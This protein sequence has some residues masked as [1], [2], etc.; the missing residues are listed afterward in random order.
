MLFNSIAFVIFFPMVGIMYFILPH[1]YRWMLLLL[2]SYV[3]Y[4]WWRIEYA[5][6]ILISTI[7]DF[8]AAQ[9]MASLA[10]IRARKLYLG[11]SLGLNLG[12][13]ATFKYF[14]FL[15]N[16]FNQLLEQ[17]NISSQLPNTEWALP[18]GISFYTFQT[19]AYSIEV[20]RGNQKPEKHFG[21]F[22]L[23]VSFFPQ[24]VAGPI[25]RA[26]NLLPQFTK[27]FKFEY[28]NVSSGIKRAAW[29]MFKKVV[30]ADRLAIFVDAYYQNPG[31]HST[32][33]SWII[34][35][36]F[37]IQIYCD[38]SGYADIAIGSARVMGF[39]LMENFNYP[40]FARNF[41]NFW[42]RWHI[43]LTTWFRD[44]IYFPLG[45]SLN[46]KAQTYINMIIV[47]V[48]S[49]LWHGASWNFFWWGLACGILLVCDMETA[50]YRKTAEEYFSYIQ[51]GG[52][53]KVIDPLL[54]FMLMALT[55]VLFRAAKFL[56]SLSLCGS[57]NTFS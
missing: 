31:E 1:R 50:T 47:F 2:A 7:I 15:V 20:Y 39:K 24:L 32:W 56:M 22:A 8:W 11:I 17:I 14:N 54:I 30:I 16:T 6:L 33:M 9:K 4:M 41:Q 28:Q 27:K 25:E 40:L 42:Q 55:L 44:Y 53:R 12:I 43:S 51:I 57:S 21:R 10:D 38:F 18:M 23:Y 36:F 35:V 46:G 34:L 29:G 49:G 19:L 37:Y 3:F 26:K 13:L 45:G 52:L 48:I 5:V